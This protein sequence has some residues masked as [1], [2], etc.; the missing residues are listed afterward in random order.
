MNKE[1]GWILLCSP[2]SPRY[3]M[4]MEEQATSGTTVSHTLYGL[5]VPHAREYAKKQK[6]SFGRQSYRS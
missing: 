2:A 5:L 6:T 1:E 3:L 4:Q